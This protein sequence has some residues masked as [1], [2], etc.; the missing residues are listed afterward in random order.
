MIIM[1]CFDCYDEK[2]K[3]IVKTI[4]LF[5][6]IREI[7]AINHNR[8]RDMADITICSTTIYYGF[9]LVFLACNVLP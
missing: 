4:L 7:P 6:G 5:R 3:M 2:S 1:L 8:N 9:S